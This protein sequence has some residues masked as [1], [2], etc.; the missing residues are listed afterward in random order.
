MQK[1]L[2]IL[3]LCVSL[4]TILG[5][6]FA[7]ISFRETMELQRETFAIQLYASY[8]DLCDRNVAFEDS[9][10]TNNPNK[11]SAPYQAYAHRV[12][13]TSESIINIRGGSAAWDS[14]VTYM[15][16]PHINYYKASNAVTNAYSLKFQNFF[17]LIKAR[18]GTKQ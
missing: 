16:T 8:A 3:Q 10:I 1:S 17:A 6:V 2:N 4:A 15:L 14:T 12:L 5:L 18:A 9:T 11:W 7:Y 13:F